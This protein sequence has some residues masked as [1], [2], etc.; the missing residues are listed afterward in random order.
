MLQ[1]ADHPRRRSAAATVVVLTWSDPHPGLLF[2]RWTTPK[3]SPS[4]MNSVGG[5]L[6]LFV[7][8]EEAAAGASAAERPD[9]P[10]AS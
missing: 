3:T 5:D 6:V 8:G 4:I 7:T 9:T 1:S 10:R 2:G